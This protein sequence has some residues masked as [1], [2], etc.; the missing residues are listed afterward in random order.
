MSDTAPFEADLFG[1]SLPLFYLSTWI[2]LI[3]PLSP[4]ILHL[5]FAQ[6]DLHLKNI[7]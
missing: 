1:V 5:G 4:L 7:T 3:L 2:E 6:R